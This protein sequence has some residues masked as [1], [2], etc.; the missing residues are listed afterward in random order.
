MR[1]RVFATRVAVAV[2]AVALEISAYGQSAPRVI[3]VAPPPMGWSS[4]NSFSNTVN[5]Q[6]VMEQAKAMA[7]NGMQKEGYQY[8][9]ID[10]G[11]WLG[12]RD[13]AGNF[14]VD[15][16]AW[17]ALAPGETAGDMSNIVRFIHSLGLKAGIYTDAGKDGCSMYPDLGPKIFGAGSEGHYEQDF[18]QFAKWGFDYV[19]VDWCGG[20]KENLDPAVQ[21]AQIARAIAKAEKATGHRL[22]LS[23]CEWG[24][25]SPWTWA[26]HVGGAP[27]DVWRTSG[28]IVDPIVAAG[29][30]KDRKAGFDKMLAN[31]EQGIHPEAQHT[32]F[33]NDPDMMVIGMPEFTDVQNWVHMCLWAMSGGPLLVGADLTKLTPVTLQIL[34][35]PEVVAID[36]DPLGL[37]AVKV[38]E[39]KPGLQV[40]SKPLAKPGT[41]ALLLL[42]RTGDAAEITA[43]WKDLGLA[44]TPSKVK[45]LWT[46]EELPT[47]GSYTVKV[48]AKSAVLARVDGMDLGAVTYRPEPQTRTPCRGCEVRFSKV[49]AHV[50]WARVLIAYVNPDKGSR[51]AELHVNGQSPTAI[52]F[53]PTGPTA[54]AVVVQ[55]MFDRTDNTNVLT[56]SADHDA[57]PVIQTIA[58]Q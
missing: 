23:L 10:E 30:H 5:A 27:G 2:L 52:A 7:A 6:I 17:P 44:Q 22:Y 13:A 48:P 53:P 31:F 25:Q 12:K 32:G 11:W 57:M 18:L 46:G 38:T 4:W 14:I 49:A 1:L 33:Y 39:P 24:K 37:Q 34:T 26:P 54:G 15:P 3:P 47:Y 16:Q 35:K 29:E 51:F 42:N 50:G 58:V 41:R 9:N 45:D 19:K 8:I 36:Q 40:W 28:D 56:F 43:Q 55:A 21:Y 20:D